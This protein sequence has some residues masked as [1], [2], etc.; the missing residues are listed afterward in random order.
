MRPAPCAE[1][2]RKDHSVKEPRVTRQ[3]TN[4]DSNQ[5]RG[6]QPAKPVKWND[7]ADK[8]SN[9][10]GKS[11]RESMTEAQREQCGE[12]CAAAALLHP[13]RH[14]EQP[15]HA[16]VDAVKGSQPQQNEPRDSH[17]TRARAACIP[18]EVV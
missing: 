15:P 1:A 3:P 4:T 7:D 17:L 9:D 13:E 11:D 10:H 6:N 8:E 2:I 14:R 5:Y 16:G 12:D 18:S